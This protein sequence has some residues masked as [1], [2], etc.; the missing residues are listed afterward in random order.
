MAAF[1]LTIIRLLVGRVL[2]GA[3]LALLAWDMLAYRVLPHLFAW[4]M[5]GVVAVTLR[6]MTG[7]AKM[8]REGFPLTLHGEALRRP[9]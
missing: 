6:Q 2:V 5:A 3:G 8:R 7:K 4:G 1:A 9:C